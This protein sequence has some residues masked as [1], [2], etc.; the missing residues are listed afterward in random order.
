[1]TICLMKCVPC[2]IGR[3]IEH[4]QIKKE[5]EKRL[6]SILRTATL[7]KATSQTH[8]RILKQQRII[9]GVIDIRD[10]PLL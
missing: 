9:A 6:L 4:I 1:M 3:A 2:R 10:L 7:L 5:N 8:G